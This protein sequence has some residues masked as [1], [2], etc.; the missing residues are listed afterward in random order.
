MRNIII[1][2]PPASGKLTIANTLANAKGYF[3]FDNHRSI[4]AT[5]ILRTNQSVPF[6]GLCNV[7]RKSVMQAAVRSNT[8]IIFTMVYGHPID[9]E[10][11][12]EY[13]DVM[14][15]SEPPLVVQLHCSRQDAMN[16]CQNTSRVDTTKITDPRQLED[17]NGTRFLHVSANH[18]IIIK[19]FLPS[20]Q[21]TRA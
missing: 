3:L 15:T 2:G 14:T 8:P 6:K 13:I 12:D 20:G 16:R 7:I 1:I 17:L 4:D 18:P 11:M 19:Q 10:I 21:E 5:T 9:D